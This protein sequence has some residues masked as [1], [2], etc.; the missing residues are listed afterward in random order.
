MNHHAVVEYIN[1]CSGS[2]SVVMLLPG[3]WKF[4]KFEFKMS[5]KQLAEFDLQKYISTPEKDLTELLS[6]DEALQ[7]LLPVITTSTSAM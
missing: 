7:K 4:R 5:E 2:L 6:P 3:E 1:R